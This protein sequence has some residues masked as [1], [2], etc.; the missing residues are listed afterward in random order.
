[1]SQSITTIHMN[2]TG[3]MMRK[4]M[5]KSGWVAVTLAIQTVTIDRSSQ[6]GSPTGATTP[7]QLFHSTLSFHYIMLFSIVFS[8]LVVFWECNGSHLSRY[9]YIP[10][11]NIC[12]VIFGKSF[13]DFFAYMYV[14]RIRT[15]F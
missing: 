2:H 15:G 8:N 4:A 5:N 9:A 12:F 3:M 14:F 7:S 10:I 1:M 13:I 6:L 11:M